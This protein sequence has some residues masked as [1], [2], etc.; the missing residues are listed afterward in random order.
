MLQV[1]KMLFTLGF[2]W[3]IYQ[4]ISARGKNIFEKEFLVHTLV[5]L[6]HVKSHQLIETVSVTW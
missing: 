6:R 5:T 2:E 1:L 3:S 4:C